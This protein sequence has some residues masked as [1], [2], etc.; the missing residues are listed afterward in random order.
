MILGIDIGNYS[1]KTSENVIFKSTVNL[2]ENLLNNKINLRLNN[3]NY[4]I[5]QGYFDTELNKSEKTFYLP[6]LF[7]AI[8]LSSS[9]IHNSIVVGL[10]L[11]QYKANKDK[12]K[13]LIIANKKKDLIINNCIR[14]IIIDNVDVYPEGLAST[15]EI[16]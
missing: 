12:L 8:A 13:D 14:Q 6:L 1:T 10:P 4:Y 16:I 2:Y 15:Y 9:D 5:G 11:N 3:Q 7:S